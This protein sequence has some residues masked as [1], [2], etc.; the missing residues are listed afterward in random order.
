LVLWLV[1]ERPQDVGTSRYGEAVDQRRP[2]E[3][4]ASPWL[5][6]Q[7]L[8][9]AARVSTFWLLFGSFFVCGLTTN[10]LVGTHLI[11]FC[12]DHGVASGGA[13]VFW[14]VVV[15][16]AR[17][18]TPASGC[19]TD[20]Y[21]RQRLLFVYSGLRGLALLALPY[22]DFTPASLGAFAVLYGL[23]WIATVPPTV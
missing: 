10:G 20:R 22:L 2:L 16:L 13:A 3:G 23:D 12:A 9:R 14:G 4:R 11:A 15:F 21:P 19:L 1:P 8:M 6:F 7:V 17:M 5:A 18:A